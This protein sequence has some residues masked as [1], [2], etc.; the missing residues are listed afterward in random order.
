MPILFPISVVGP[1]DYVHSL[2][3]NITITSCLPTTMLRLF[4]VSLAGCVY[5]FQSHAI[6]EYRNYLQCPSHDLQ[7][8]SQDVAI[9]FPLS[10]SLSLSLP[11]YCNLY[12]QSPSGSGDYFTLFREYRNYLKSPSQEWQLCRVSLPECVAYILCFSFSL[13]PRTLQLF[14]VSL[15]GCDYYSQP[16][17]P[18]GATI[19]SLTLSMSILSSFS[20][21]QNM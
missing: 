16:L 17:L 6:L 12:F 10:L 2:S 4:P 21:V 5:S 9:I 8:P 7:R 20:L 11:E 13:S 19:S 15:P 3:Q 14:A 18:D 1:D